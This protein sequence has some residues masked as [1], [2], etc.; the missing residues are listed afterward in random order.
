MATEFDIDQPEEE[1]RGE[2]IPAAYL[3]LQ[4]SPGL[5]DFAE[6]AQGKFLESLQAGLNAVLGVE[7]RATFVRTEQSF[8]KRYFTEPGARVHNVFLHID[9]FAGC[10]V[11]RFSSEVLF[12]VLDILLASPAAADG[13][14]GKTITDI[15]YRVL[16]GF[17][18]TC[19]TVAQKAWQ[20]TPPVTFRLSAER[21]EEGF[22]VHGDLHTIALRSTLEIDGIPGDFDLILPAFL[23][24]LSAN[25]NPIDE[26]G[27]TAEV[28]SP[29]ERISRLLGPSKV[30]IEA[31][32][33]GLTIRLRE[34]MDLEPGQILLANKAADSTFQ[35]F[36][37]KR[38][39][40]TGDLVASGHRYG[41]QLAGPDGATAES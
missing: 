8:L 27:D 33:S 39:Q 30:E 4:A 18:D 1:T 19:T 16:R 5:V 22:F 3:A 41:F 7:I 15:E 36:V 28:F 10:A 20:T 37:N 23:V 17:L 32:L 6:R 12:K 38:G 14:R 26:S 24:R 9:P 34:L 25:R 11:L 40:F 31:V 21:G 35:C 13:D 29:P 2:E